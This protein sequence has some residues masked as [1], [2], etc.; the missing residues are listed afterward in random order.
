MSIYSHFY[1]DSSFINHVSWDSDFQNLAIRFSTGTVWVYYNV[2]ENK[3][4]A[5]IQA[6]S[7][8]AYFNKN[9]RDNYPSERYAYPSEVSNLV[10]EEEKS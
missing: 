3:Y 2:P 1:R 8:G 6:K 9:I 10:Q 4:K 7:V 5:L